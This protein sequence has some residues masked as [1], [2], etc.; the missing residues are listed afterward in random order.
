MDICTMSWYDFIWNR[1]SPE[2]VTT[3]CYENLVPE[4]VEK[5][6]QDAVD[7]GCNMIFTTTPAF[8]QAS[9]KTAIANPD[10]RILNCSLDTS[11]PLHPY[12]LC[13]DARGEIPYG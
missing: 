9:V 12:L 6:I 10:V 1:S 13:P 2:E 8:V 3:V 7:K 11:P 4:L 5:A